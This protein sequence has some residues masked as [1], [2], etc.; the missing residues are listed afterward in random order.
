M[1]TLRKEKAK[2]LEAIDLVNNIAFGRKAES[3]LITALRRT[4]AFISDLSVI[5]SVDGKIIGHILLYPITINEDDKKHTSLTLAPMSVIPAFH[6]KSVGKLL[7]IY[8]LQAA[9]DLGYKSVV[10][11]GHPS[12]Y[13][14]F[15]FEPASKWK[16]KS[17]FPAPDEAFMAVELEPGSLK[18]VKGT[19]VFP[20]AFDGL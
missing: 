6:K 2:D 11:L 12:Y 18:N 16:I 8:S 3:K 17:P 19:V 5:A 20:D 10:V 1:I 4:A 15:G 13:P 14:K 9:K 7:V